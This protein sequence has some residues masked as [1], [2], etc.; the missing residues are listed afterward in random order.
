RYVSHSLRPTNWGEMLGCHEQ[1]DPEGAYAEVARSRKPDQEDVSPW[2]AALCAEIR[3]SELISPSG[4]QGADPSVKGLVRLWA[5]YMLKPNAKYSRQKGRRLEA[6]TVATYVRALGSV[7]ESFLGEQNVLE[8][9][10]V[11]LETVYESALEVQANDKKRRTLGSAIRE[12]HEYLHR[13]HKLPPISSYSV[14]SGSRSVARVDARVLNEEQYQAVLKQLSWCGLEV[15][16]PR[17][18]HAAK[19]LV[20]F[21]FRLGLRRSEALML[22]LSDVHFPELSAEGI[23][24]VQRRHPRMRRMPDDAAGIDQAVDLMVRPSNERG[25]KTMNSAR[26][27]PLTL[28]LGQ[29]ELALL[30]D[31]WKQR[32]KEEAENPESEFLFCIP[33]LR[34]RWLSEETLI[35]AIHACMR[36]VTGCQEMR[37]HH[38]RHSCATWLTL[39]L[40]GA[41]T[42][43]NAGLLLSE[44][45]LTRNWLSETSRLRLA[46]FSESASP[47]RKVMHIVSAV[48]GHGKPK[49]TLLHYVHSMPWVMAQSW[50]WKADNW[51]FNAHNL[52]TIAGV[53]EPRRGE[54]TDE[55]YML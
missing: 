51:L 14:L 5:D 50:Q 1:L 46:F 37:F 33:Q 18:A 16:T 45:E 21:G 30:R 32:L 25:L 4:H 36:A 40:M 41:V 54:E 26:R 8:L 39:K 2:L 19:L 31:W 7:L 38:L 44:L 9:G 49:T 20:I 28:L 43:S 27:L 10:S 42:D 11:G 15:R 13:I 55:E 47:T 6:E 24:R 48:M 34:S 35:P 53:S 3:E 22:K 23:V 29:N 52:A 17:L 12:F